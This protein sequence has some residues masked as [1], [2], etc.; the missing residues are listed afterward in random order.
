MEQ[1]KQTCG[2]LRS[3]IELLR[4]DPPLLFDPGADAYYKVSDRMLKIISFMSVDMSPEELCSK[5]KSNGITVEIPELFEVIA[6]L[7]Q[8]NLLVPR[9]GEMAMKQKKVQQ[10]KQQTRLL[11]FAS[12]YLFFRLPPWRPEK[13]FEKLSPYVS[14]LASKWLIILLLIPSVAGY[15]LAIRSFGEV[16]SS[17]ADTL[18]WAGL[19]KYFA[20]IIF[21][22]IVHESAH[23]LAAI[24]FRCRVRGIGLGFMLFVPRLYT[25]TTDSWRLPRR[26]R[27]LIDAAGIIIELLIGGIAALLWYYF[28]PGY[29]KSTFFYIFTVS[30][31]S[32]LLVNGNP[33]IRYDGYYILSDLVNIENLMSRSSEFIKSFWRWHFLRLGR[34]PEN[35]RKGFLLIFGICSFVYRIFLY[36][37]II[38]LIYHS[39]TKTLAVLMLL[40]E[41]YSL[42]IYPCY[43]EIKTIR[44]LSK[45]SAAKAGIWL[46]LSVS[47]VIAFLLFMPLSW[48]IPLPGETVPLRRSPVT[49]TEGG[50]LVHALDKTPK[51]VRRGEVIFQLDSPQLE[52]AILKLEKTLLYDETLFRLQNLDEKEFSARNVTAE[53]I[54]SDRLALKELKR[55]RASLHVKAD[56]DG[57]FI[58]SLP[59]VSAGA[60]LGKN[61]AAGEIISREVAIYAYADDRDV[62]H[63]QPG[64][65]ATVWVADS[66]DSYKARV[67][68]VEELAVQLKR[69]SVLQVFGGPIPVYPVNDKE[70]ASVQSLY[71]VRLEFV[72]AAEIAPGRVVSVKVDYNEQ[73]YKYIVRFILSFYHREF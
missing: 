70:F 7:Q 18:S 63:I 47:G 71:R 26:Q 55:R 16:R 50:Y 10:Y 31:L 59:I 40:L 28:P 33:F 4:Q 60:F 51:Q 19:V 30:T 56:A 62:G 27:L 68:A 61:L 67:T 58:S 42:L 25:D 73:L 54:T 72:S 8:N 22:K 20:A 17:F 12:A 43:R 39:F 32:T 14:F 37:S 48:G 65:M 5:L 34:P 38:L 15:L 45:R 64:A 69:S 23:S 6:F 44:Q 53:K 41:F 1:N 13:M 29:A 57:F 24:H 66:L 35:S 36:T 3:D 49:V 52:H 2:V 11:R 46:V 9:Y 21:L